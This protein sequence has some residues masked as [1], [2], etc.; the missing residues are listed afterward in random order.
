MSQRASLGKRAENL[1]K[2][3]FLSHGFRI[4]TRNF[5]CRIGELDLVVLDPDRTVVFVEVRARRSD[6]FGSPAESI[7]H[8]KQDKL[9][10][11]AAWYIQSRRLE[12]T[13]CRIDV[14]SVLIPE[15]GGPVNLHHIRNAIEP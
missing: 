2:D 4:L 3:Y 14:V 11:L 6:R 7:N 5:R 12:N 9:L 15:D 10:K 13:L 1:A 8:K